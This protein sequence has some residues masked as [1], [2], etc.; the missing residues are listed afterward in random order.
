[1]A[2]EKLI[3]DRL[4]D[5]D[6]ALCELDLSYQNITP[7]DI[8]TLVTISK[9]NTHLSVLDISGNILNSECFKLIVQ[10]NFPLTTLKVANCGL[11]TLCSLTDNAHLKILDVS[12]NELEDNSI[13]FLAESKL[14]KLMVA[15]NSIGDEGAKKLSTNTTIKFL[16]IS[17]N[18]INTSGAKQLARNKT[19]EILIIN[20]N[21]VQFKGAKALLENTTLTELDLSGNNIQ[22]PDEVSIII[23]P[24][25]QTL[26][27]SYNNVKDINLVFLKNHPLLACLNVSYNRLT[28][29]AISHILTMKLNK[30]LIANNLLGDEGASL[31]AAHDCIT[32]LDLSSNNIEF[33]GSYNLSKNRRITTLILTNNRIG[34]TGGMM[35]AN[36]TVLKALY[37]ASNNIKDAAAY[38]LSENETLEILNLNYNYI[39]S[40]GVKKLKQNTTFHS[41]IISDEQPPDFTTD[42]LDTLF[43]FSESFLC[44]IGKNQHFQFI[45]PS[46]ARVL[47]Y[48][49]DQLLGQ[50]ITTFLH[51]DDREPTVKNLQSNIT[52]KRY[53][54]RYIC[55][56]G[57]LRTIRWV[58]HESHQR[59]YTVG[60]DITLEIES[61]IKLKAY[62]EKLIQET[63][64][65]TKRN[66]DFIAHIS[67][68]VRNPVGNILMSAENGIENLD[69]IEKL[70]QSLSDGSQYTSLQIDKQLSELRATQITIKTCA[71]HQKS[72]LDTILETIKINEGQLR[73]NNALFNLKDEL[74]DI[75]QKYNVIAI[76]KGI[77]ISFIIVPHLTDYQVIAD[78]LQFKKI[79]INILSNALKFTHEGKIVIKL[80]RFES[81]GQNLL[82]QIDIVDTGIGMTETEQDHLF[83]RFSQTNAGTGS[84]YGGSG[85]GMHLS[86]QIARLM[87]GKIEVS[88]QKGIG[89]T[90]SLILN[91]KKFENVLE[92]KSAVISPT[93]NLSMF[94]SRYTPVNQRHILVAEDNLT[95]QKLLE[96]I[97]VR[98]KFTYVFAPNGQ[99]AIE[100]NNNNKFDV[101][102]MD[103]QMPVM[104]G[105]TA[106][107]LIRERE[108]TLG[109]PRIPI[110]ALTANALEED[111]LIGKMAGIDFYVTK[112]YI[113]DKLIY[114]I[115]TLNILGDSPQPELVERKLVKSVS[116]TG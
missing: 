7:L 89:T 82:V 44:I 36:N 22:W 15:G 60:T 114:R 39:S 96:R 84:Q 81:S 43:L 87:N 35:L 32:Y 85:V 20:Y 48:S 97:L 106:T 73:L 94:N 18:K 16:S 66:N 23:N 111:K 4:N 76:R 47:G 83:L 71:L 88:S 92:E 27:L 116:A 77:A 2:I 115:D 107:R 57:S 102:L 5:N 70:L 98:A 80:E 49:I 79:I 10:S 86:Q 31:L 25:I 93:T 41:M 101:I 26:D 75:A 63:L 14:E 64:D 12:N 58:T 45:N 56:D 62:A 29:Q 8:E 54:N 113:P 42:N 68:E 105:L 74:N 6:P 69:N 37:L 91:L 95:N 19:I 59:L 17:H 40:D 11:Q 65:N 3:L 1:M 55:N 103:I 112:P 50:S 53:I 108:K 110:F 30:L 38:A 52:P 72:V 61:E 21:N 9:T 67:H 33:I 13:A 100:L 90:F 34:D 104:D 51:P 99:E 46:L 28:S 109:L 24:N 78:K